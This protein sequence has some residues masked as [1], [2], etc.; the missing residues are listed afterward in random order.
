[1]KNGKFL[2]LGI[3]SSC[4]ETAAAI[5]ADGRTVLSN[6][7]NSQIEIHTQYGGVVP[8]I[9]SRN[10][11]VNVNSVIADALSTAGVATDDIDLIAVTNGPGLIGA[12]VIGVACA[13][14]LSLA[15]GKPLIGVNHMYGHV[16]SSFISYP[17][18]EP[19]FLALVVSGGHT[20]IIEMTDYTKCDILAATRDDAAGEAFDK[21]ARVIGL[22][23]PGGPK[24]DEAARRG[25]PERIRFKRPY[26]S[27]D[28]LDFSFSGIKTAVLNYVNTEKQAGR[29]VNTDDVAAG[30]QEAVI[31]VLVQNTM[32]A[33]AP[34]CE[35]KI[36]LAG[37]VA[38][39]GRLREVL[40]KR[41]AEEGVMLYLPDRHLCTDNAAMI[42][43][44]GY[45]RFIKYG[46]DDLTLDAFADLPF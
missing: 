12:L 5:V 31:E 18:L 22:G 20:N 44:A 35:K 15:S 7:I 40:K 8:E 11:L 39:N 17:E 45:Y 21:V 14:A 32:E 1:M 9:A 4:D 2:T 13:K 43:C 37:G 46:A 29:A 33:L 16:S 25:N 24:I 41:C 28:T 6:V 36:V 34:R 10:H 23:Y 42:A 19:P 30:F 38:A 27:K 26:L 3:E